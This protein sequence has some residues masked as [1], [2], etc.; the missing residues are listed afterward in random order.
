MRA[1][2]VV[3]TVAA[4]VSSADASPAPACVLVDPKNTAFSA[5]KERKDAEYETFEKA[6]SKRVVFYLRA[7]HGVA[8]LEAWIRGK[9]VA[10]TFYS[11]GRDPKQTDQLSLTVRAPSGALVEAACDGVDARIGQS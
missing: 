7:G 8:R 3:A 4:L 2:P 9:L 11:Y 6:Q 5:S 1:L 10:S